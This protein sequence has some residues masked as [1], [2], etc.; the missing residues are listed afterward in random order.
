[1]LEDLKILSEE[2]T[3][4][5]RDR[6]S[7][8][9]Q[10]SAMRASPGL[11]LPDKSVGVSYLDSQTNRRREESNFP[12]PYLDSRYSSQPVYTSAASQSGFP[13]TAGGYPDG[14]RYPSQAQGYSQGPGPGYQPGPGYPPG[15]GSGGSYP[16]PSGHSAAS[17]YVNAGYT[18]TA[19][20]PGIP[21]DQNYTYAEQAGEYPN[22]GYSVRQP[23]PYAGGPQTR[24]PRAAS[25]YPFVSSPQDGSMRAPIDGYDP[26]SP[27][28]V[29]PQP[30]RGAPYAPSRGTPVYDPPLQSRDGYMREPIREERRRR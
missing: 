22:Q 3:R 15:Y 17:S 20:R 16:S 6:A 28:M 23:G 26:Y 18:A 14:S 10:G 2:Y 30:G 13:S 5:T 27:G 4:E 1:M 25:G 8:G 9:Y 12:D 24:E 11:G 21:N 29:Q 7:R 19:G